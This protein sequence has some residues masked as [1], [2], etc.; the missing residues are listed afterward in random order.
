[1]NGNITVPN[2][3]T[4]TFS[5]SGNINVAKTV[6][7]IQGYYSADQSFIVLGT[8]NCTLSSDVQLKA[9]GSVVVNAGQNGGTFQNQRDLCASDTTTPAVQFIER[10]DFIINAPQLIQF[11]R[12]IQK[13][14]AP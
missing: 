1:M 9:E 13:E 7:N 3:S 12:P 10:P 14:I 4:V 6:T 11:A 8:N 5:V 2:G